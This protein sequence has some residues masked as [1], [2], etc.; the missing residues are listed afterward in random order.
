[1][2]D[3]FVP[4]EN[5]RSA[6]RRGLE[7]R[8]KWGRGGL[9]NA[10]ASDQG[11]GSGVQRATNLANGDAVSL[12]TIQRMAN[13]FSRHQ[14]NYRPNVKESDGGP[15]AGTVAWL[16]WGGNAGKAWAQRILREQ[17]RMAGKAGQ[18][19]S[20][21]DR[22][23]IRSIRQQAQT[24]VATTLE[25]EPSASDELT[26]PVDVAKAVQIDPNAHPGA[27]VA[28][29]LSPEQ[30]AMLTPFRVGDMANSEA[31]HI[32][33]L[34]LGD[35]AQLITGYKNKVIEALACIASE[36]EPVAGK[37]N[38]YG[39]FSGNDEVY[40][41]FANYDSPALFRLRAKIIHELTECCVELPE[42]HGFTP[43]LTLGYLPLT[44]AMPALDVQS[45][46]MNFPGF[47]LIWAGERID[48][49]LFGMGEGDE[50]ESEDE[51]KVSIEI[52]VKG[53]AV[54]GFELQS[55]ETQPIITGIVRAIK[56]DGEWAL[57]VLG[58]P[59]GGHNNGRDSD[60][61][62]FS[63]K[64]NIYQ[65]KLPSVP[66]V[67]FHGWDEN[68]QP[69]TEPAYIGMA[70]Y[71]RTDAKGHWYKVILNK[72]SSYA[73]RVWNAAKQGIARASSGSITHLVRKERDGHITHWPVAELSIF[74]AIG[75]RQP[76][77]QYAVALPVLKSV[78][79]AAGL[80]WPLDIESPDSAQTPEDAAIGDDRT[81]LR[82]LASAK[83]NETDTQQD[84]VSTG[85]LDNMNDVNIQELVAQSVASALAQRDAAAKAEADRQAEIANAVKSAATDAA[86]AAR[87]AMQA[88]L[89]AAKAAADAAKAEAA[90]A[91][92][93]PG[94]APHVAKFEA[95]YDGLSIEDLSFMSGVLNSAKGMRIDGRESPGTTEG[96]RRAL[97]IRLLDSSEGKGDEY[98]SAKSVMPEA[99]KGMKANELNYSTLSS[100]GDEWIGVTYSTQLWDKIRLQ[101]QIV[102]RIPTV[103]VPQGS[104]SIV[105][106][107]NTT[108]PTFYKVA[109]ATAQDSNP[110]R[111]TPT[112]T[113]SRMG[114]TNKTLT[115]SKLGAAVNYSGELEE[116][117]LIPWIAELRRDLI[118]EGA[119]VLE[120]V[121]IDGDTATGGTTNINDIGGTPGG[122]EAFLLFDGFRKLALVTNTANSRSAGALTIEDYLETIKLM[123]LGGKNAVEKSRVSYIVDMFTHWKS[124]ELAELKTQDV[125]SMP[126]IEEGVLR[127][128]YGYD[129]L[130]TD[131]MHRANQ[132]ATYGL[133]ANTSGKI[134]L[135]TASNNT[136]GSILAVRWDQWRLGYKRNW[137]FEVQRDALSDSTVIVGMMRVGMVHRDTEASAISYNVTL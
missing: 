58:V 80:T 91:R 28:L 74:D 8:K 27:M 92:R 123:G 21:S 11:I 79:A 69:A 13:F 85:V 106:P 130:T 41:V 43:H 116:D 78:Y 6:A 39:R 57:E 33:L 81:S 120:H 12:D 68:N 109:Q 107:V 108:S 25:L 125:Y 133:K 110:G 126:T 77:N 50:D 105:I 51:G 52:E 132:D 89:D 46:D 59:F 2:A 7:L 23:R 96:L 83:A 5:V 32:T 66:A 48:Y 87:D 42:D 44:G 114:T 104:E 102:S 54:K 16:L 38:G 37:L 40:P 137:T 60:G 99:V 118:V 90:E 70:T 121:V 24:I 45:L 17:E 30:Q 4:P 36:C 18:R 64:T 10:E 71:D 100:Y 117:S 119:E 3:S 49:M 95:K 67:Y 115:V 136:T 47:S 65:D 82:G 101:T 19:N 103:V 128:V 124:L 62:Y 98:R 127:R 75:K 135:D 15:T 14:K 29:M 9:S 61:E 31:D 112:V 129:V 72:A 22:Q 113:T 26:T 20:R 76:A 131:N 1:M 86:K 88:E 94:G 97:A 73:Q 122:T 35:D 93:L 55:A 53:D 111:V 34:Y 134:D 84:K 56:S 63:Q